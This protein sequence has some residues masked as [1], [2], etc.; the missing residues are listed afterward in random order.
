MERSTPSHF[1]IMKKAFLCLNTH[2][3]T[4]TTIQAMNQEISEEEYAALIILRNTGVNVIEAALIAKEALEKGRGQISRVRKCL[5]AGEQELKRQ[6]KTVSFAKAVEAALAARKGRRVRTQ[7]DFRYFCKR[8][9]RQNPR[10]AAR[11]MRSI[12]P[13]ECAAWLEKAYR[14]PHQR[15]KARAIL[16]GVFSTA[17]R[18]GW[19][20][21]NPVARVERPIVEEKKLPILTREEIAGLISTARKYEGGKC[22]AA[23]GMMLYAGIRPHEVARLQWE[24]VDLEN[25]AIYIQP[26]HSKTGGARRVSIHPPLM[27]ILQEH[28]GRAQEKI[29]PANW[30]KHWRELRRVAGWN[31]SR[32]WQPDAL[33][34]TYA[35]Y[36]LSHFRSYA[37]LQC[38]I[39]HRDSALLRTRYVDQRGVHAAADFWAA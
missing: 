10:L 34:H 24:Q 18:Q 36:H 27:R 14:S 15:L 5:N 33:R 29:C 19:C 23:V 31:R 32:R 35:S 30:L 17:I 8:L 11:R 28:R 13:D 21:T 3:E 4:A 12:R 16:S 7:V 25:K 20:D 9:M 22:L 6:E 37:E 2:L 39:G 26:R 1:L 38:E